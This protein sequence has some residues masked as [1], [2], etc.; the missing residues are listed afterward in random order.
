MANNNLITDLRKELG[1]QYMITT[2]SVDDAVMV[3]DR[4]SEKQ[5]AFISWNKIVIKPALDRFSGTIV[6][7][8]IDFAKRYVANSSHYQQSGM[9]SHV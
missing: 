6:N 3:T 7:I 5:L 1:S 2:E 9:V 8:I 4:K